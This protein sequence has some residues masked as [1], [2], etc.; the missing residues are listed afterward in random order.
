MIEFN[1][2]VFLSHINDNRREA[3]TLIMFHV[4]AVEVNV[5]VHRTLRRLTQLLWFEHVTF[6]IDRRP[7]YN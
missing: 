4:E 7:L 5:I 3:E 6:P 2:S 1:F